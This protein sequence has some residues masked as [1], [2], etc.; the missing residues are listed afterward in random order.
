MGSHFV[1]V[2]LCYNIQHHQHPYTPPP[3]PPPPKLALSSFPPYSHSRSFLIP[4]A[5]PFIQQPFLTSQLHAK[6]IVHTTCHTICQFP[7]TNGYTGLA[8]TVFHT[9]PIRHFPSDQC[10]PGDSS[11]LIT[12]HPPA[13]KYPPPPIYL[14]QT[15]PTTLAHCWFGTWRTQLLTPTTTPRPSRSNLHQL[16]HY[17]LLTTDNNTGLPPSTLWSIAVVVSALPFCLTFHHVFVVPSVHM[18][19]PEYLCP[20]LNTPPPPPLSPLSL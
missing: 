12:L 5:L 15:I 4:H 3:P 16:T 7:T 8:T 10:T 2:V 13:L 19:S 9:H 18:R 17:P 11:P 20:L 14:S 1:D 6:E